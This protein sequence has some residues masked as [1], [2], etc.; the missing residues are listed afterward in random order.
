MRS[1]Q[2]GES[3][4]YNSSQAWNILRS[5]TEGHDLLHPGITDLI[6][7]TTLES[8]VRYKAQLHKCFS[9]SR[10]LFALGIEDKKNKH[11]VE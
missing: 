3:F 8:F 1:L 4:I 6:Q 7:N 10:F 2:K 11:M 5:Y 9:D